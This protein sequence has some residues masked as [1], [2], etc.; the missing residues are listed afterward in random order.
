MKVTF[1][2]KSTQAIAE[3]HGEINENCIK[4]VR[5]EIDNFI[6][7]E[8][9]GAFIFDF[10]KVTLIDDT[11]I[12]LLLGRYK[13]LRDIPIPMYIQNAKGEVD[14]TLSTAG[15]YTIIKKIN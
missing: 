10:S 9:F 6:A 5:E 3:L 4:Q 8:I 2:K 1:R 11:V 15:I 13:K 14:F 7:T 12:G